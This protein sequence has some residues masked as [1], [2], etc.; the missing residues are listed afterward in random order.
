MKR[1]I[2][3]LLAVVALL[4]ISIAPAFAQLTSVRVSMIP[5]LD[6]ASFYAAIQEGYFR[7]E[8]LEVT[9]QTNQQGG[10]VGIPGLVAGA[11]DVAYSNTPTILQAIQQGIDLRMIAGGARNPPNPP[12]QVGLIGRKDDNL[13][14]GKDFEGKSIAVNA[15]NNVQWLFA[16][17]WV[18]AT[19]GDPDKATYREV[20]FP[21]MIDAVVAK[22]VDA[23]LAIDPFLTFGQRNPNLVI[24]G[25]PFH[26][27]LPGIQAAG[28][29]VTAE[30]ASKR[31]ELVQKFVRGLAKGSSWINANAGKE[32]FLQLVNSY[33]KMEPALIKSMPV[34][35]AQIEVDVNSLKKMETLMRDNGMLTSDIDLSA[36]VLNPS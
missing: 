29:V 13:N 9:T 11:Y 19:G 6:V 15:R 31:L 14:S 12:E 7:E 25:W 33:T 32:P 21:Q 18:K 36:K 8:G 24:I 5:I 26:T 28:Y 22:Q 10:S 23:A 35:P 17:A 4:L 16:R 3:H 30:T 27:V 1:Y 2:F 34:S 20:A